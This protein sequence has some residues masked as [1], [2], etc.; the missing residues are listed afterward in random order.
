MDVPPEEPGDVSRS[1]HGLF[2]FRFA[3]AAHWFRE[4]DPHVLGVGFQEQV[5]G[6]LEAVSDPGQEFS[7]VVPAAGFVDGS[8]GGA[9]PFKAVDQCVDAPTAEFF[10][11]KG[12]REID[13]VV[14]LEVGFEGLEV[15]D[16][17]PPEAGDSPGS[18]P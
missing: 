15:V 6:K 2:R 12:G 13:P 10:G 4:R 11:G 18:I 3:G 7:G 14:A 9:V 17:E 16:E 8:E 1:G 5:V